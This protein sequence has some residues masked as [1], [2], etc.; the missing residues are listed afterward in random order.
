M[1]QVCTLENIQHHSPKVLSYVYVLNITC[2]IV[3]I[4]EETDE[5]TKHKPMENVES[6]QRYTSTDGHLEDIVCEILD[7]LE[8][9]SA[10][11]ENQG[12]TKEQNEQPDNLVNSTSN[13][14]TTPTHPGQENQSKSESQGKKCQQ[15]NQLCLTPN[16][17]PF[18]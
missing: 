17:D 15:K 13:V 18:K 11:G 7:N 16:F 5:L 8:L 9:A 14:G 4:S 6:V 3:H 1:I 10:S 2:I 12:E